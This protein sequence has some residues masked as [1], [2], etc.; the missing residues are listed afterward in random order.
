MAAAA[1]VAAVVC[2]RR[3]GGVCTAGGRWVG[4]ENLRAGGL[5]VGG[6]RVFPRLGG[7]RVFR[8]PALSAC[9][10]RGADLSTVSTCAGLGVVN[11]WHHNPR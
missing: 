11:Q 8:L 7:E 10:M 1:V 9:S 5:R 4:E 3:V 2:V 6:E